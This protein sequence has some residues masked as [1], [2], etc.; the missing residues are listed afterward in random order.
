MARRWT[1]GRGDR[2]GLS[3]R[4]VAA[5]LVVRHNHTVGLIA[6]GVTGGIGAYKAVEIV[7]A[8]EGIALVR[9]DD[10]AVVRHPMVQAIVRAYD[11][12]HRATTAAT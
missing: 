5:K 7:R 1:G 9:F 6:L 2:Q 12:H 4:W 10:H 3:G 8:V 11:A